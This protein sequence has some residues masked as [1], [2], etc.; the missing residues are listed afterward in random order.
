VAAAPGVVL[1]Q[2]LF[3]HAAVLVVTA[4]AAEIVVTHLHILLDFV[5]S[6]VEQVLD[7]VDGAAASV[8]GTR[9]VAKTV[10]GVQ[11]LV[12]LCSGAF[13][14]ISTHGTSG[15]SALDLDWV[16]PL[17]GRVNLPMDD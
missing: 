4:G 13:V 17:L 3:E 9:V 7:Q 14:A 2:L 15:G 12:D 8:T 16:V 10:N 5:D 1:G 6:V 11:R